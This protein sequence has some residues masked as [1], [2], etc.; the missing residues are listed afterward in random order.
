M[1]SI[2]T[3]CSEGF[4]LPSATSS[5][6]LYFL[7]VILLK[8]NDSLIYNTFEQIWCSLLGIYLNAAGLKICDVISPYLP[9]SS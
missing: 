1:G 4:N 3:N 7:G 2:V 9:K 8:E 6:S 5:T